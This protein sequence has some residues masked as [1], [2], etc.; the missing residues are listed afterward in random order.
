[1]NPVI[2]F[3]LAVK[4][5]LP[6]V[7]ELNDRFNLKNI[8]EADRKF[9]FVTNTYTPDELAAVIAADDMVVMAQD[10][11]ITGCLYVIN[12][13]NFSEILRTRW[14]RLMDKGEVSAEEK[15]GFGARIIISK[16]TR[17]YRYPA[18]LFLKFFELND[19]RY[20]CLFSG[21]NKQNDVS[22]KALVKAYS[23]RKIDETDEYLYIL[24]RAD[25]QTPLYF[26]NQFGSK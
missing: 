14:Q 1:M 20:S 6:A 17:H 2:N 11:V 9:G 19:D 10:D 23:A 12:V 15:A 26:N 25:H 5:D 7:Y 21:I 18:E 16:E 22:L 8:T 13:L 3:R 24:F 4:E